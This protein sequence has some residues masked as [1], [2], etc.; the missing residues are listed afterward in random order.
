MWLSRI[1][2]LIEAHPG[3][4]LVEGGDAY[5]LAFV[6]EALGERHTLVWLELEPGDASDFVALGNA[7]A[8]SV[9]KALGATLL[10]RALP[11]GYAVDVLKSQL[12]A[13]GPLLIACTR[14]DFNPLFGEALL[15]LQTGTVKVV[16][17]GEGAG[18]FFASPPEGA[19]RL[20]RET[21]RLRPE[22]ARAL[23][24]GRL[25]DA[26]GEVV[27]KTS[28]GVYLD[29]VRGVARLGGGEPP[30]VPSPRGALR[31]PGDE[32]LVSPEALLDVLLRLGRAVEALELA[33]MSRPERVPEVLK[34]AGPVYQEEG[35]LGRLRLL[36]ES[37]DE[38]ETE[39]VLSWR[40]VAA[41]S[42][43]EHA[44]LLPTV[45]AFLRRFEAPGLRARYAVTITHPQERFAEAQRAAK[46]EQ[47]PLTL[48]QLGRLH[49][50]PD[51][52]VTILRE[53]VRLAERR[54]RPY[55]VVRNA[56]GL[57]ERL[58]H[59]GRFEEAASWA[60]WAL[61]LSDAQGL[62]DGDRR[63]R[64]L[65]TWAYA[66][67]LIGQSVGLGTPLREA[68]RALD[69]TG[70]DLA[71]L[72]RS[73]LA[74]FELVRGDLKEAERLASDNLWR[75]PRRY[76]GR[77][78]VSL[79]RVLL[80]Q[81]RATEALHEARRAV[82]LTEG[83]AP[84]YALH[85]QLALG[86]AQSYTHP[87]KAQENLRPV[88]AAPDFSADRRAGAALH[89]LKVNP[90]FKLGPGREGENAVRDLLSP[91]PLAGLKLLSGPESV[92]SNVW[93]RV[94]G[95]EVP[96]Q[97]RVLG[98]REV[99]LE[100]KPIELS[101]RNLELLVL[102]ALKPNG[103][104][105]DELHAELYD[106]GAGVVALRSAVSRLRGLVP[107]SEPP[108]RLLLPYS[109][110]AAEC[111]RLLAPGTLRQAMELYRGPLLSESDAPGIRLARDFLE[112][113]VRQG[114]LHAGDPEVLFDLART[115]KDDLELWEAALSALPQGD[116]RV[117]LSRAQVD[118]LKREWN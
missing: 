52:G 98:A 51:A 30:L 113:R 5:G 106:E 60:E 6:L 41:G 85:A 9:N 28:D 93:A 8:G 109:L 32:V 59:V 87:E 18:S 82:F 11:F 19:L 76:V 38:K 3:P 61:R 21:L 99:W 75:S 107:V 118:R 83:E 91:L 25:S 104:S 55:E 45:Q 117:P 90:E 102:L 95:R 26:E 74:N 111:E 23:A 92:F 12:P 97:I 62:K 100:G 27:F 110:D 108:Y 101:L 31:A 70:L 22:E 88:L 48:F 86:M 47:T 16:L 116:P 40:L 73:T 94:L 2:N 80:E 112:E 15:G 20:S 96:L 89:L 35:L 46:A 79:V 14:A 84:S 39:E 103:A 65:N 43:G 49:T 77:F 114:A 115:L 64:L 66:R 34:E 71:V 72:F 24:A 42:Q 53:S 78:T 50:N 81:G 63:L 10:P 37:L 44:P 56:G 57:S 7:L 1:L 4:V 36:L 58:V 29:F 69:H 13:L 17:G 68:N 105:L 54:G 67:L 33:V